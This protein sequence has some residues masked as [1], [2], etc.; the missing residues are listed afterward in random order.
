LAT[1]I[2]VF[3]IYAHIPGLLR[4]QAT[5]DIPAN[6]KSFLEGVAARASSC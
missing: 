5:M 1:G 3:L 2:W 4:L 6:I